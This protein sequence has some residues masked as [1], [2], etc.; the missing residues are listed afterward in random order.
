MQAL[1]LREALFLRVALI[2]ADII[3]DALILAA[4]KRAEYGFATFQ[5]LAVKNGERVLIKLLSPFKHSGEG[6]AGALEL[7]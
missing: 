5:I 6:C 1:A 2:E 7:V 4:I 3:E